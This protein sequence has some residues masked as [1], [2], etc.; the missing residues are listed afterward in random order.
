MKYGALNSIPRQTDIYGVP[1]ELSYINEEEKILLKSLGGMGTPG[2]GGVPQY[3]AFTDWVSNTAASVTEKVKDTFKEVVSAGTAQTQ[4]YNN[5]SDGKGVFETISDT[6]SAIFGDQ[7]SVETFLDTYVA[8]FDSDST[9]TE[10]AVT[11]EPNELELSYDSTKTYAQLEAEAKAAG[12]SMFMFQGNF[13]AVADEE[14]AESLEDL[15]TTATDASNAKN[16]GVTVGETSAGLPVFY[17][18]SGYAYSTLAGAIAGNQSIDYEESLGSGSLEGPFNTQLGLTFTDSRGLFH[19][20]QADA[21]AAD[22][23]YAIEDSTSTAVSSGSDEVQSYVDQFGTT[24]LEDRFLTTLINPATGL[25]YE[26]TDTNIVNPLDADTI[27]Y[28]PDGYSADEII[29]LGGDPYQT[30]VDGIVQTDDAFYDP[31]SVT[32]GE[33]G[34]TFDSEDIVDLAVIEDGVV[35]DDGISSNATFKD[36]DY[37]QMREILGTRD[38][39]A[40]YIGGRSGGL[41]NRFRDSYFTRFNDPTQGIDELVR[42]VENADGTKSYFNTNNAE[43]N[44]ELLEGVRLGGPT[45]SRKIGEEDVLL[46]TQTLN[47][48]GTVSGTSYTDSYNPDTDASLFNYQ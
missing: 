24:G 46:G 10:T 17:D 30:T 9:T 4:T 43:L 3:N 34:R 14:D 39:M 2:P 25:P 26:S 12:E 22:S 11:R 41:W 36:E 21:D 28:S 8:D 31:T 13:Y 48:D 45:V 44:P 19:T 37:Q 47:P 20:S 42:V 29:S 15:D 16:A 32:D 27:P 5:T 6:A 35:V 7:G 38:V 23:A 33:Y 1:H 40:D 18:K